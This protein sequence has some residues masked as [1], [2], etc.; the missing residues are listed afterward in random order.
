MRFYENLSHIRENRLP[1]RAYYIP[2]TGYILLNGDWQFKYYPADHM[3]E[4]TVTTWDTIPVPSCWQMLGYEDPNYTNVNYPYPIDPPYVPDDNPLGMYR[5]T[6]EI[7][8]LSLCHYIVFEGVSSNAEL[9]INDAYVGYTQGSHLQAEFDISS[10]VKQGTNEILVKVRKWCSG[11]YLEDQD[12]FRMNGIFRDVYLLSRPKGHIRD[13]HITTQNNQIKISMEGSAHI[14]LYDQDALLQECDAASTA[15][16]TV[17]APILWNAEKPYLYTLVFIY[18]EETIRRKV[19]FVS[20]AINE[21][22][23]FCVNGTPVK[24]K[25]VNHHDTHPTKGWM[26][27]DSDLRYDLS[28]MKKL[29]INCIRTSHYPPTPKFLDLCDEMG[30]YVLLETDIETHGF[31]CRTA[32]Y[33]G[34]DMV[35]H[36]EAW[37]GNLPEWEEA[38]MERMVRAYERDKNHP[39]IFGWSTGNE[40]G[41]CLH[42]HK[43]LQY[44]KAKDPMRLTHA[45]D[46]SR[47]SATYPEF[48]E[49]TDLYSLM[50]PAPGYLK[51][52]AEDDT[53][54][55]PF[56]LCEYSHAM[57]NGPGDVM[58]YWEHIYRYPKLIGGCIWEW[59]DHTVLQD[60]VPKY[61]GDFREATH[62]G[63]FCMDGLVFHDRSF[64]AGSKNAKAVYQYMQCRI[65]GDD[66]LVTNLYDFTNLNAYHFTYET[67]IDGKIINKQ[68]VVLEAAPKETVKLSYTKA[69]SCTLGAYVNCYLHDAD[70]YEVAFVQLPL[71]AECAPLA[72]CDSAAAISEQPKEFIIQGDGFGYT[73]SKIYGTFTSMMKNGEEQLVAMPQL[74]VMRAPTDNE[75]NIKH[76]WYK[77]T[78]GPAENFDRLFTKIYACACKDNVI[79]VKGSLAGISHLPFFRFE[80]N[81]TFYADGTVKV[82]LSGDVRENCIWLPRLG[83]EFFTPYE[84][85]AFSYY[86]RGADENYCDMKHHAKV[87]FFEST[88]D[89]EYVPYPMPQE[90]GNHTDTRQLQIENGLSFLSD[91]DFEFNVSHYTAKALCHAMHI[92]ELQK[93]NATIIRI[94]YKDSGIGSNSCG[95]ELDP[96]YRLDEKRIENFVFYIK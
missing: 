33:N 63:N 16:F 81:Y 41:H 1:A 37:I 5:R 47:A 31:V 75:R 10:F 39:S 30:F 15:I 44:V 26:M 4:E 13:L 22:G 2:E 21:A 85:D 9:Y 64:K 89:K 53:K 95:P 54:Q 73:F 42:H 7:Q 23:A 88:A 80:T 3:E 24:L 91:T 40:S 49:R 8:D 19:G 61:G 11:S 94:D 17:D 51:E 87:G 96:K 67:E 77:Q 36:P 32:G 18:K 52:Y 86:G 59:A 83:F 27:S 57:G 55:K 43:M 82:S 65:E 45:E 60:G 79:S 68:T 74:T 34:Y 38:Y 6:F 78:G 62:D 28:Q 70:G 71:K 76:H 72:L 92:D 66:L 20:Y 50:Y 90:H 84:K 14:C 25:G 56:F 12:F 48:Y 29:N 69:D 46:A 93:E 58:D 35:D